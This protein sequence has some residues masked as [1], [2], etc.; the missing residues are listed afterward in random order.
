MG[1][2]QEPILKRRQEKSQINILSLAPH[3]EL[4]EPKKNFSRKFHFSLPLIGH[5]LRVI[6][7]SWFVFHSFCLSV[8]GRWF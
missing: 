1:R 5:A 2:F 3:N 7:L 4:I 8:T 6:V